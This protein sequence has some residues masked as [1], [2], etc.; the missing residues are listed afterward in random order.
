ML[1]TIFADFARTWTE[2][3]YDLYISG[4][5]ISIQNTQKT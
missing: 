2:K 5:K 1:S 4:T 3:L